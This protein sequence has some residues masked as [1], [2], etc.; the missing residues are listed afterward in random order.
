LKRPL[1]RVHWQK[2]TLWFGLV[3]FFLIP[4]V[5]VDGAVRIPDPAETF[6]V[7]D[8]ANVLSRETED[9]VIQY[10]DDLQQA[11]GAQI[12]VATVDFLD[13]AE[14]EDYAYRMFNQ[15]QIGDRD[16][17]NGVLLLLVI[18]EENYWVVQGKGLEESLSSGTLDGLLQTYLEPDFARADY[19]AGVRKTFDALVSQMESIYGI[20][21]DASGGVTANGGQWEEPVSDE[22]TGTESDNTFLIVLVLILLFLYLRRQAKK[23]R[24]SQARRIP[25]F[26]GPDNSGRQ[27]PGGGR[28]PDADDE[29]ADDDRRSGRSSGGLGSWFW[30]FL[31]G[32]LTS[33]LGRGQ[34]SGSSR[35]RNP[36]GGSSRGGGFGGGGFGGGRS[37]RGG[38]GGRSRGGGAGRR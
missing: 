36:G 19:D 28:Q 30:P 6:Y 5:P 21:L 38:G 35:P 23:R 4:A 10:N 29:E 14:I 25:P 15:W 13:G 9:H 11:S 16:K 32:R 12:V 7:A 31:L 8:F 33:G 17:N 24:E 22:S 3:L 18:G 2:W 27:W 34:N 20:R 26:G 37:P 1:G